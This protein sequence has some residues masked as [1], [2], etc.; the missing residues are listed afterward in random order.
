MPDSDTIR[1]RFST[2][3]ELCITASEVEDFC[4]EEEDGELTWTNDILDDL[5]HRLE[6]LATLSG[7]GQVDVSVYDDSADG[8]RNLWM[9]LKDAGASPRY[10]LGMVIFHQL[11]YCTPLTSRQQN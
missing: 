10:A 7:L 9:D 4:A 2:G 1:F 11:L 3:F 8:T 6:E 5:I